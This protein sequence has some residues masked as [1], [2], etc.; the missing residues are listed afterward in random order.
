MKDY[1]FYQKGKRYVGEGK[2]GGG[3]L[4]LPEKNLIRT[5]KEEPFR[6]CRDEFAYFEII[7]MNK[8]KNI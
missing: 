4:Q 6:K 7:V 2:R 1:I 3:G 5:F 8:S